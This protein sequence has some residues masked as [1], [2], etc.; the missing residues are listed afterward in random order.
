[1]S[2]TRTT[3][4]RPAPKKKAFDLDALEREGTKDPFVVRAGGREFTFP[5]PMEMD[6][7][8]AISFDP[9]DVDR[10]IRALLGEDYEAFVAVGMPVWKV[11]KLVEVLQE[12]YGLP[13]E[14]EDDA[15]PTS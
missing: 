15:S 11:A 10:L 7:Q 14:G 8:Q 2:N 6:Y 1:M 9:R 4:P 13:Q 3:R 12:Y 5:D